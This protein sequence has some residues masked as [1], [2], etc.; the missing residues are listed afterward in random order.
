MSSANIHLDNNITNT[1]YKT[2]TE[3]KKSNCM[4]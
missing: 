4:C 1:K 2:K 3:K